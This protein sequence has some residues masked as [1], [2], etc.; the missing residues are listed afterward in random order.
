MAVA[1]AALVGAL[2]SD[3]VAIIDVWV[4]NEVHVA[5]HCHRQLTLIG[6]VDFATELVGHSG[7][8]L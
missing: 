7:T 4:D 1:N 3:G 6:R 8:A 5:T 2:H